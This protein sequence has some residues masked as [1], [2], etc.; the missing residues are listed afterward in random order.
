MVFKQAGLD[1]LK[2]EDDTT[3]G[4]KELEDFLVD[5][6]SKGSLNKRQAR[7]LIRKTREN[8]FKEYEKP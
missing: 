5:L 4:E 3:K 7:S 8:Q 2:D 6:A 1:Y